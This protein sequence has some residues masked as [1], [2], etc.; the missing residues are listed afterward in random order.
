MTIIFF[1]PIHPLPPAAP[2]NRLAGLDHLRA[3]AIVLVFLYHYRIFGDPPL[4]STLGSFGWTGVDLFFVLSGY[5]IGGQLLGRLAANKPVSY[6]EFYFKR[7]L[8]ILP[9]YFVVLVLYFTV[10]AFIE[11]SSLPPLWRFLTFTQ[12]F[13][14]DLS[15]K[16]AFS[17]AWSLCIEEQFYLVL[18]VFIIFLT[19]TGLLRNGGWVIALLVALGLAARLYN[20]FNFVA[21]AGDN[22]WIEFYK[23]IYYPTYNRLDGLLAG[24]G[25]AALFHFK[26]GLWQRLTRHGNILLLLGIGLII[27]AGFICAGFTT[28]NTAAFG[29]PL[30]SLAY[31]IMVLAA[32]SP[33]S[34]LYRYSSFITRWIATLSYSIYLIHKQLIHLTH[35]ILDKQGIGN[36][37]YTSFWISAAM[38]LLGGM[39]LHFTVER[40]FLRLRDAILAKKRPFG[41]KN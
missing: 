11:R 6:T 5:L 15:D 10:P 1:T 37:S 16:A 29:F 38:T 13:G 41:N 33:T 23:Y 9:A 2:E 3:L 4:I 12:N 36:D 17:H 24:L 28:F 39:I 35:T 32:L 31:G 19:T 34:V 26:P 40:P 22:A 7:S 14:L 20:W 30:I 18:P 25:L 27:A 21:S 8:R